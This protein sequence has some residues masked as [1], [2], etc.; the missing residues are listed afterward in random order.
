MARLINN[1][2]LVNKRT[3]QVNQLIKKELSRI[4]LKEFDFPKDILITV[5]RVE[6]SVDLNQ[7]KVF[8]SVIPENRTNNVLQALNRRI[9]GIQQKLNSRLNMKP[10]PRIWLAK[11]G[12]TSEAGRIEELLEKLKSKR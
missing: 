11:E 10:I 8:L 4:I 3:Q 5:T 9:Y 12:E 2:K 6:T 1:Y 7:A